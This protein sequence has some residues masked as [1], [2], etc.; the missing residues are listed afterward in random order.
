MK[1]T[2]IGRSAAAF[3][4]ALAVHA[5]VAFAAAEFKIVTANEKGTYFAIGADLAKYVAPDADI[6][7]EVLPSA[8][9]AA[10]IKHLRYDAGVK[11]AVVQAD[12]FQAFVD[13]AQANNTEAANIIRPL[14]V[15]L[16]LYNTEIHF[17]GARTRPSTTC[18]R[19]RTRRSTA[20]SSAAARRSSRTRST[21]RCSAARCPRRSR[22][23][24][25]TRRPCSS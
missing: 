1:I 2:T 13:R 12:V 8:G 21:A 5:G 11:F 16:P 6:A 4:A 7:L 25:R 14:R 17:I 10:N 20:A 18:T 23:G 15:I 19:S 24:S 22:A 9:S 3:A